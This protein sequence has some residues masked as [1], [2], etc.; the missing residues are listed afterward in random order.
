MCVENQMGIRGSDKATMIR[1]CAVQGPHEEHV[2]GAWREI[3][4][5]ADPLFVEIREPSMPRAD[6]FT[7][8]KR[9]KRTTYPHDSLIAQVGRRIRA[10]RNERGITLRE[11]GKLAGLHPF[12]VM[13]VELGQVSANLHTIRAIAKALGV[14]PADLLNHG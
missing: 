6:A 7:T 1:A 11:F 5:T 9:R 4:P 12:H 10:L 3:V 2:W 13:A 14:T 8:A